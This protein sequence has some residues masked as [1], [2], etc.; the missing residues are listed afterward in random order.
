MRGIVGKERIGKEMD[1]YPLTGLRSA[2][3]GHPSI[4]LPP[5]SSPTLP[6]FIC[7]SSPHLCTIFRDY[8]YS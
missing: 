1:G 5:L 2:V 8:T 7:T 3:R 4:F 6:L